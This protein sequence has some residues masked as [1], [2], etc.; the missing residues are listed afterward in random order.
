MGFQL[1]PT[2][3]EKP[4]S[5]IESMEFDAIATTIDATINSTRNATLK[6]AA[7]KSVSP[8]LPVEENRM[9]RQRERGALAPYSEA[10]PGL[11]S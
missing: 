4:N 2:R 11:S 9:L 3:N 7:R 6:R 8:V 5:R 1:L 10:G